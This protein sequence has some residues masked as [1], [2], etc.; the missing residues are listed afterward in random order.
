[1]SLIAPP[2]PHNHLFP[3]TQTQTASPTPPKPTIMS[4]AEAT[5]KSLPK[6]KGSVDK[7]SDDDFIPRSDDDSSEAEWKSVAYKKKSKSSITTTNLHIHVIVKPTVGNRLG[8][9]SIPLIMKV[10]TSLLRIMGAPNINILQAGHDVTQSLLYKIFKSEFDEEIDDLYH[11]YGLLPP[12]VRHI[13]YT[14]VGGIKGGLENVRRA[15][16]NGSTSMAERASKGGI[17]TKFQKLS[18]RVTQMQTQGDFDGNLRGLEGWEGTGTPKEKSKDKEERDVRKFRNNHTDRLA[19]SLEAL[20]EY[21]PHATV[22]ESDDISRWIVFV[23]DRK[24]RLE[25]AWKIRTD[26][27]AK[28][29]AEKKKK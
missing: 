6:S 12:D 21:A 2:S 25:A 11:K 19:K 7:A 29:K 20:E 24:N 4:Y 27:E 10:I 17:G 22:K 18:Q 28:K 1:M 15:G 23:R 9:L 13:N 26:Q 3:A 5:K 14:R 8:D 16:L